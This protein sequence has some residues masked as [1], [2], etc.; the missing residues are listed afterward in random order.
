MVLCA[1]V[2]ASLRVTQLQKDL[3]D[4]VSLVHIKHRCT[5]RGHKQNGLLSVIE[6]TLPMRRR[7]EPLVHV[8]RHECA[9]QDTRP[10]L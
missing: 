6:S 10:D 8:A 3:S 1:R 7:N 4:H 9:I 5:L 2:E